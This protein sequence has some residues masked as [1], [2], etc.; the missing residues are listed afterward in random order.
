MKK[1][2]I[3]LLLA[4]MLAGCAAEPAPAATTPAAVTQPVATQPEPS[5]PEATQPEPALP[6]YTLPEAA[7]GTI[8]DAPGTVSFY[9]GD[10]SVYCGQKVSTLLSM[11]GVLEGDVSQLIPGGQYSSGLRIALADAEGKYENH[12]FF[13]AVNPTKEPLAIR[14]CLIYSLTFNC[15]SG[16]RFGLGSG[17]FTTG[18]TTEEEL[19]AAWGAPSEIQ[20]G[21]NF[22]MLIYRQNFSFLQLVIRD[23]GVDQVIAY[24]SAHLYPELASQSAPGDYLGSDAL[25][26]LSQH[27]DITP[28]LSQGKGPLADI[29]LSIQVTDKTIRLGQKTLALT[30]PWYSRYEH[31]RLKIHPRR[32]IYIQYPDE[33]GFVVANPGGAEAFSFDSLLLKGVTVF[34][35]NYTNWYYDY[36]KLPDFD[37]HG[38]TQN[39]TI[40]D[41]LATLGQPYE[42]VPSS[43][44]NCCFVWLHYEAQN[45]DTLRIKVDPVT[46][47][48]IELRLVD[49]M[50]GIYQ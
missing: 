17:D 13:L 26:L 30:E 48:I 1:L 11:G 2:M 41:V 7:Q 43:G 45:R 16:L 50:A 38:V 33:I 27:M 14:D 10:A 25:L 31:F 15:E 23:T 42:V 44:P 37:Y 28:Y 39:S 47:Q 22:R 40:E 19:V 6:E 9:V 35:S 34:N 49:Y 5:Q 36:A 24:H 18:K 29:D 21:K 32:Y 20:Q 8:Q 3:F 46:N 4:A 12:I